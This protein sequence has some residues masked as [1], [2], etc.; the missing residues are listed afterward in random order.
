MCAMKCLKPFFLLF[1]DPPYLKPLSGSLQS[2]LYQDSTVAF[3]HVKMSEFGFIITIGM[4]ID[5]GGVNL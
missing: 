4:E 2:S 3:K 5:L 1:K